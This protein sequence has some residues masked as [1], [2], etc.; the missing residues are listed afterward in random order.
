MSTV[1]VSCIQLEIGPANMIK[2]WQTVNENLSVSTYL[3]S[4]YIFKYLV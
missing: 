3:K 1:T 4:K 2:K